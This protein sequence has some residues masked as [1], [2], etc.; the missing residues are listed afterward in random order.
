MGASPGTLTVFCSGIGTGY[1]PRTRYSTYER[2][3]RLNASFT[4]TLGAFT[5]CLLKSMVFKRLLV[6]VLDQWGNDLLEKGKEY[7]LV[8]TR[9]I[10]LPLRCI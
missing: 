6:V 10:R 9:D 3:V 5:L 7:I 2:D 8:Q 4:L 1:G